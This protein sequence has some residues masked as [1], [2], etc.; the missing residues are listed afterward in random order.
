[1]KNI[2]LLVLTLML[3]KV[4]MQ[5][6]EVK[7]SLL[8]EK[9][10]VLLSSKESQ[11][12]YISNAKDIT[13]K[14]TIS[15]QK[16]G[17]FLWHTN[18]SCGTHIGAISGVG[19]WEYKPGTAFLILDFKNITLDSGETKGVECY[20]VDSLTNNTLALSKLKVCGKK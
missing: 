14:F 2:A 11:Q 15:F 8:E 9:K 19:K 20:Q 4:D 17:T 10:W 1:M 16:D 7:T 5:S 6:Q 3:I 18:P 13:D 12:T